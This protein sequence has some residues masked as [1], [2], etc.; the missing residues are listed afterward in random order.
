MRLAKARWMNTCLI[1]DIYENEYDEKSYPK[2]KQD[3]SP[4][5]KKGKR[6]LA[7][8]LLIFYD[9]FAMVFK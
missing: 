1:N 2:K 7:N 4:L 8:S 6:E 3:N 5:W 9:Q